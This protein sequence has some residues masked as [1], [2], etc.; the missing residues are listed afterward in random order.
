MPKTL[1]CKTNLTFFIPHDRF[2]A[3]AQFSPA[4]ELARPGKHSQNF[5]DFPQKPVCMCRICDL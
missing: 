5:F 4:H 3:S 1:S 2:L